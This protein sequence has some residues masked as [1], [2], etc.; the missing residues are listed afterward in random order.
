[1]RTFDRKPRPARGGQTPTSAAPAPQRAEIRHALASPK[2][3]AK[4]TVGQP[5]DEHEREADRVAEEVVRGGGIA[6]M[7]ASSPSPPPDELRRSAASAAAPA[8]AEAPRSVHET[9]RS[10]GRP[11]E[12]P[13]RER[14]ES[15]FGVNFGG[16]R[17]HTESPSARDVS[18]RAYTAGSHIAFAAG[19]YAP[20]TEEGDLLLAH[21]LTHVVQQ[22]GEASPGVVRRK[23]GAPRSRAPFDKVFR[24][25]EQ[26]AAAL[27]ELAVKLDG[28]PNPTKPLKDRISAIE[29][30]ARR[31]EERKT[32]AAQV[33]DAWIAGKEIP[34]D[35]PVDALNYVFDDKPST[36][37][38]A[39][40]E[41]LESNTLALIDLVLPRVTALSQTAEALGADTPVEM[42][43]AFHT[44]AGYYLD[45]VPRAS[46]DSVFDAVTFLDTFYQDPRLI[47]GYG[48]WA[49]VRA[50]LPD[51]YDN[52]VRAAV[53]GTYTFVLGQELKSSDT[54]IG[55]GT[56]KDYFDRGLQGK[57][58]A[59][60]GL[61]VNAIRDLKGMEERIGS[62]P[63][64]LDEVRRMPNPA[65]NADLLQYLINI[66]VRV[67]ILRLWQPIDPLRNLLYSQNN[68]GQSLLPFSADDRT[69]WLDELVR[70]EGEFSDELRLTAQ[71]DI[72]TKID[73]WQKRIQVLID[74]IPPE[75]KQKKIIAAIVEQ[76]PFM[77]VAGATAARIGAWVRLATQSKWLVALAEGATMTLFSAASIPSNAPNRPQGLLGWTA[78]LAV[79]VL[80]ARVGRAFF[81]IGDAAARV[82]FTRSLIASFGVRVVVPAVSLTALQTGVQLIE[83]KVKGSGGETGFTE[84][85]TL[86]LAL[87]GI[88]MA[89]GAVTALPDRPAAAGTPPAGGGGAIVKPTAPELAKLLNI[90][91]AE[92][93]LLLE[94]AA[95][96]G[97]FQSAVA[98][99]NEAAAKG[100]VTRAQF[101]A[102]KKQGLDLADFLE[103]RL[104]P[105]AKAG[106]FGTTTPDQAKA[107][108]AMVRARLN[109]LAWEAGAKVTA[110][111]PEGTQGLV[112]VGE[113][114]TQWVYD[115]ASPPKGLPAL[116]AGYE[117]RGD[118]VR[119][120]PSGG[121]EAAD[122]QG[123]VLAQVI[124]VSAQAAQ[125]LAKTVADVAKGPLAQAGL[126]RLRTQTAVPPNLLEAQLQQ[127]LSAPGGE[128]A[129]PRVLQHLAR[130]VKPG[131]D[132]AWNG[133]SQY[134]ALGGDPRLL[135]RSLAFAQTKE[136]AAESE[137]LAN[138]LLERMAG[139]DAEAV[140]GFEALYRL[141]PGLTAER[142]L[143][144]VREFHPA[145]VQGILQ[146]LA[147]LEPR[148]RGLSKVIGPLTSGAE[149]SGRGGLGALTSGVQLAKRFPNAT[150]VFE[151]PVTNAAG[152]V[153]RVIDIS[154]QETQTTRVAGVTKT[155]TVEVGAFEVKEVSSAS[156][157]KRADQELARDIARDS[158]VRSQRLTPVNASRPFFE[159]FTWRIRANEIRQQAVKALANPAATPKQ[160]DAKMREIVEN[161][162]KK[163]FDRPEL[164][165]LPAAELD[166]YRKAFKG[167][168][169]VEF[170]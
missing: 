43:E 75:V 136:F 20:G 132:A 12:R 62:L 134:L 14:M 107:Y 139:W 53:G 59:E 138:T 5:G 35:A 127:A 81:D 151:E 33:V 144:L 147:E 64:S 114:G 83:A 106:A 133:L 164:K 94:V 126:S 79:N 122:T 13:I 68:A 102:F 30:L 155:T 145:Q 50:Q 3:Q 98:A 84:L 28:L 49:Y 51:L 36:K 121:W 159:T 60:I 90:P 2:L 32:G 29:E 42:R 72:G 87:N 89:L 66:Q 128:K 108:L 104:G 143:N 105:L 154:V 111:L 11:L 44:V 46:L 80:L 38:L 10:P 137:L 55:S 56:I 39:H 119:A 85:L 123:N 22:G 17:I 100:T 92:A 117:K 167:V 23:N 169:F 163:V 34:V 52:L 103:G 162:L 7:A 16:V 101:E 47:Q 95:R 69:R 153:V 54:Q 63:A 4:L 157:G 110:L 71:P 109:G 148:S 168:P 21:E 115:R 146:S 160:I 142:L 8:S 65:G 19:Q 158:S 37:G 70:L 88:G 152:E 67:A 45:L 131:N 140:R 77:F 78:N 116:R 15:R 124:P 170:F 74:E 149:M 120:L 165:G 57:R 24:L 125:A 40:L 31:A 118:T 1:V 91:Q 86:N 41:R 113:G 26:A 112:R 166:G 9:L 130:F 150:L 99:L 141:K 48:L 61:T 82:A 96:L 93:Q 6:G 97:D 25:H 129:V 76:L 73:G 161:Q 156:L 27:Q 58:G 18:A 135:A